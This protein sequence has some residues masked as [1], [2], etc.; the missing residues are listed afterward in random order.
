MATKRN[1]SKGKHYNSV[2]LI[3]KKLK[4]V[5]LMKFFLEK[6]LKNSE[7]IFIII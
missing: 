7:I 2:Y 4:L 6:L 1:Y 5:S 3:N